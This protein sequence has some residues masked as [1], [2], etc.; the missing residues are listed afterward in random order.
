MTQHL[1]G[2]LGQIGRITATPMPST[3]MYILEL[4]HSF[5]VVT[6]LQKIHFLALYVD[7]SAEKSISQPYEHVLPH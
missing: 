4:L 2:L 6:G 3:H 1:Y 5:S 7:L